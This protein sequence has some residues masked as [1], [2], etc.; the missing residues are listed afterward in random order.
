MTVVKK[1]IDSFPMVFN[2]SF[3]VYIVYVI[4]TLLPTVACD[5]YYGTSQNLIVQEIGASFSVDGVGYARVK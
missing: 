1:I 3:G 2:V 5:D 4:G